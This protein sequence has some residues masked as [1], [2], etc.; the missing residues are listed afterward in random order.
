V[1][2]E[3]R[4]GRRAKQRKAISGLDLGEHSSRG[5][6]DLRGTF[7]L[8]ESNFERWRLSVQVVRESVTHCQRRDGNPTSL[9]IFSANSP[10]SEPIAL[11]P[12]HRSQS[13]RGKLVRG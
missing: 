5:F 9:R 1:S 12:I 13:H 6:C 4:Q 7:G 3:S 8:F 11:V 10:G 2:C